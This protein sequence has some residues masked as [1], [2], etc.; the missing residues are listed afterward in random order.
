[1]TYLWPPWLTGSYHP[2]FGD[3]ATITVTAASSF[4]VAVRVPGWATAATVDGK[5]APNGTLV[6]VPPT[7]RNSDPQ[8]LFLG[9]QKYLLMEI[10]WAPITFLGPDNIPCSESRAQVRLGD[11]RRPVRPV[12]RHVRPALLA[13][14]VRSAQ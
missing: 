13:A 2:R 1:V 9:P 8:E 11:R 6:E 4:T 5:A 7:P 12:R 3:D 14:G 10:P